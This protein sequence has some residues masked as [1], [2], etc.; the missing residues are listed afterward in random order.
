M[1]FFIFPRLP[2]NQ[3]LNGDL[4]ASSVGAVTEVTGIARVDVASKEKSSACKS[5]MS[6]IL[7]MQSECRLA[8]EFILMSLT[9]RTMTR[10]ETG[11]WIYCNGD[12]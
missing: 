5:N 6:D 2:L 12:S 11:S 4:A 10:M 3:L 7:G 1:N 9:E 8:A